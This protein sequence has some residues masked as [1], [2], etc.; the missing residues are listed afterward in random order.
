MLTFDQDE[1]R[2]WED[3]QEIRGS[4][5]GLV[6]PDFIET[7]DESWLSQ[8]SYADFDSSNVRLLFPIY[9]LFL[10]LQPILACPDDVGRTIAPRQWR[11]KSVVHVSR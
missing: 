8:I 5:G 1:P 11:V 4:R 3:P 6:Q 9:F 2:R 10:T 7:S